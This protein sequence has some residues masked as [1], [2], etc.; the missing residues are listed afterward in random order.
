[1]MIYV[2]GAILLAVAV[3]LTWLVV[4]QRPRLSFPLMFDIGLALLALG[5]AAN[6]VCVLEGDEPNLRMWAAAGFGAALMLISYFRESRRKPEL[7]GI[8]RRIM[9]GPR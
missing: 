5:I 1:M 2:L 3:L 4:T 9:R 6:G 7:G 8:S